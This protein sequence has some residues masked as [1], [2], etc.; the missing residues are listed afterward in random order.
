MDKVIQLEHNTQFQLK[1]LLYK[2]KGT[3]Q[4]GVDGVK[5]IGFY[6]SD[7]TCAFSILSFSLSA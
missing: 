5:R 7:V 1:Q 4:W 2:K 3:K 6:P